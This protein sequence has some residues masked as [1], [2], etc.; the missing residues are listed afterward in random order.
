MSFENRKGCAVLTHLNRLEPLCADLR[1]GCE[2]RH[3][4]RLKWTPPPPPPNRRS[5]LQSFWTWKTRFS[6][7]TFLRRHTH[8]NFLSFKHAKTLP[9]AI[10]FMDA[11]LLISCTLTFPPSSCLPCS[12]APPPQAWA[13]WL[14]TMCM[15]VYPTTK[16]SAHGPRRGAGVCQIPAHAQLRLSSPLKH[17]LLQWTTPDVTGGEQWFWPKGRERRLSTAI[18]IIAKTRVTTLSFVVTATS[19]TRGKV[20]QVFN[21]L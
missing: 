6:E 18:N 10:F 16:E 8:E 3:A 17:C 12:K 19:Q 2:W 7:T 4:A 14:I 20:Q 15:N 5:T 1:S 13:T 21:V 9:K 11:C